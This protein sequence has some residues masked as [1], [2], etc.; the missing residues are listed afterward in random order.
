MVL[1]NNTKN[2]LERNLLPSTGFVSEGFF[3]DSHNVRD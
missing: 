1:Y 3:I 2:P